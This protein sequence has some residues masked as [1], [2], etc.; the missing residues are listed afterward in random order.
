MCQN[1]LSVLIPYKFNFFSS[2]PDNQSISLDISVSKNFEALPIDTEGSYK[3]TEQAVM[4]S[5]QG[6]VLPLEG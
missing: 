2:P 1:F 6:V 5:Q 4:K 3:C